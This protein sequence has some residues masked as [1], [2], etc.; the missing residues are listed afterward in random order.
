MGCRLL[1]VWLMAKKWLEI[2]LFHCFETHLN[3]SRDFAG[4][5]KRICKSKS[6]LLAIS[7]AAEAQKVLE[8]GDDDDD[9]ALA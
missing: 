2:I 4:K 6:S 3:R 9:D 7:S 1:R 8:L 5:E